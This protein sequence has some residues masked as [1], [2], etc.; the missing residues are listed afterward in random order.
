MGVMCNSVIWDEAD[1][2]VRSY[3]FLCLGM[4]RQK[5]IQQKRPGLDI[6]TTTTRESKRVLEDI[7][8]T[9]RIIAYKRYSFICRKQRKNGNKNSTESIRRCNKA[10]N[11]HQTQKNYEIESNRIHLACDDKTRSNGV[12]PTQRRS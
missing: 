1:A 9:Q 12:Y 4:E 11:W 2:R 5:Q 10:R 7:F 3:L 8:I 6:Q